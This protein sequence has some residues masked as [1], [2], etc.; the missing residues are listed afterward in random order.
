MDKEA[1]FSRGLITKQ[2]KKIEVFNLK[3]KPEEEKMMKDYS[4]STVEVRLKQGSPLFGK[5]KT[6][7]I[8]N[9]ESEQ[10]K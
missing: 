7:R 8:S 9:S 3:V 10:Y 4:F 6:I 1:S 2:N 5:G